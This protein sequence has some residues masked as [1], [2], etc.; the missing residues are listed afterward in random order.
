MN[1]CDEM[2]YAADIRPVVSHRAVAPSIVSSTKREALLF[3]NTQI[4]DF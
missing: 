4:L 2:I 1:V 3:F